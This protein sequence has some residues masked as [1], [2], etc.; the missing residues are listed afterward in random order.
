[1]CLFLYVCT[2]A[3]AI[4]GADLRFLENFEHFSQSLEHNESGE[5]LDSKM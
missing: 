1:M 3:P 4:V 2:A 5:Y